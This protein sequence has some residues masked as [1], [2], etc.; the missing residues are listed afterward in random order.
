MF[1]TFFKLGDQYCTHTAFCYQHYADRTTL[2]LV[3]SITPNA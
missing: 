2:H 1:H 3:T